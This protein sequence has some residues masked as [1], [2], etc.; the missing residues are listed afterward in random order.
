MMDQKEGGGGYVEL[1]ST[2]GK[3][4]VTFFKSHIEKLYTVVLC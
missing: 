2:A 4:D 1:K 3:M